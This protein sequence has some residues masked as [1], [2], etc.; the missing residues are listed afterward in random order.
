M[1]KETKPSKG[2]V[3]QAARVLGRLGGLR[4]GPARARA[5]SAAERSAIA[6]KGG[7]APRH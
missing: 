3:T 2:R 6:R 4:G 5:L 1:A 7:N